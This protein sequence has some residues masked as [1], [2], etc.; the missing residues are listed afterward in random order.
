[1]EFNNLIKFVNLVPKNKWNETNFRLK[2]GKVILRGLSIPEKIDDSNII[3]FLS[4]LG[5]FDDLYQLYRE[6]NLYGLR[7]SE[8]E[9]TSA[10]NEYLRIFNDQSTSLFELED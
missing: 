6:Y 7:M 1:M 4:S 10:N 2:F 3:E 9:M 5:K 8:S